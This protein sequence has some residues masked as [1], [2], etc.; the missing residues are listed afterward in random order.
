M[1]ARILGLLA[2]VAVS[3]AQAVTPD[4]IWSHTRNAGDDDYYTCA[5]VTPDSGFL[6][7]GFDAFTFPD[8]IIATR[9]SCTGEVIWQRSY[10]DNDPQ[11]SIFSVIAHNDE[12]WIGGIQGISFGSA[13]AFVMRISGSGDS[14]GFEVTNDD[15]YEFRGFV[16]EGHGGNPVMARTVAVEINGVWQYRTAITFLDDLGR[17]ISSRLLDAP[18]SEFIRDFKKVLGGYLF[19]TFGEVPD[20]WIAHLVKIDVNGEPLWRSD[21]SVPG[22]REQ[23]MSAIE[24]RDGGYLAC[25]SLSPNGQVFNQGLL[26]KYSSDGDSLWSRTYG[27]PS[28]DWFNSVFDTDSGI[29]AVGVFGL[30][31][32][33]RLFW[34][35]RIDENGDS[36]T[37]TEPTLVNNLP[38]KGIKADSAILLYGSRD[39]NS[40]A[41][42]L[43]Y[44]PDFQT[45]PLIFFPPALVGD[46]SHFTFTFI[47][48]GSNTLRIDGIE[49]SPSFFSDFVGPVDVSIGD[50]FD[51]NLYFAPSVLG[52]T[53][54]TVWIQSNLPRRTLACRG[55]GIQSEATDNGTLLPVDFALHSPYPNPFNATTTI[56]YDVPNQ[57]QVTLTMYDV[58]GRVVE[59]LV[60]RV[61]AVGSHTVNW[62]C[63]ECASGLYFV[64]MSAGEFVATQKV[65]L[66]K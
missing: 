39:E 55:I 64:R 48:S 56:S 57:A 42:L 15:S 6:L 51:I 47:N 5:C 28:R 19:A 65:M 22:N 18:H 62:N 49:D 29:V 52:F 50:S 66:V 61:A 41:A 46:T 59:T 2:L 10:R 8:S 1:F 63:R 44:A 16:T 38:T 20:D 54:D 36:L 31:E 11:L 60:D 9:L 13:D 58:Q 30:S 33:S 53:R 3:W 14:L 7:I 12:F 37:S 17:P 43:A 26:V 27:G 32:E 21:F 40:Y 24:T 35:I 45:P 34:L 23:F 25:G 4:L